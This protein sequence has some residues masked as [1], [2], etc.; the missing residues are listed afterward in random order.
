LEVFILVGHDANIEKKAE[1]LPLPDQS[2]S[3]FLVLR[4]QVVQ[5][6][7]SQAAGVN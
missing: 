2:F 5:D 1:E 6:L 4:A 3:G 7:L